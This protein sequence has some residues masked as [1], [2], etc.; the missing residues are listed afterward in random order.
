MTEA[1]TERSDDGTDFVL[2]VDGLKTYFPVRKG[3]WRKTVGYVKA[4]DGVSLRLKKGETL[5]LVGESGC[6]KTTVGRSMIRLI[7]P[8]EGRI[9][10]NH[11][12]KKIDLRAL[13]KEEMRLLRRE[14]QYIFQ[15]PFSSLNPRM[16]IFDIVSEP[17]VIN[18]I[19]NMHY[20]VTVK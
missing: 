13:K 5:G 2:D 8:T 18:K 15:D 10:F 6:G 9:I 7:E 11:R 3:V 19:A 12:G 4:V 14:L 16:T 1:R 20:F 17:L